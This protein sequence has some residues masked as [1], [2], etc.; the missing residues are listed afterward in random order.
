MTWRQWRRSA[1]SSTVFPW[2]SS[3]QRHV[4][5]VC[6]YRIWP[7]TSTSASR[8]SPPGREPTDAI[9][10]SPPSSIGPMRNWVPSS[11]ESFNG[12]ALFAGPFGLDAACAVVAGDAVTS[13]AVIAAVLRLVDCALLAEL[14]GSWRAPL[15]APRGGARYALDRLS[16]DDG[17][18]AARDRQVQWVIVFAQHA[19]IGLSS[20]G[21][22]DWENRLPRLHRRASG[23]AHLA[24]S[25]RRGR[26]SPLASA[27]RPVCAFWRGQSEVFR[28]ADVA[29]ASAAATDSPLLPHALFAAKVVRGSAA[30]SKGGYRGR[31]CH[32]P[33]PRCGESPGRPAVHS[34]DALMWRCS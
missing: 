31:H 34:S 25:S 15:R 12:S 27:L 17:V 14:P 33:Q 28:W 10:R 23:R 29:V 2:R 3:W 24:P 7:S 6:R 18:V 8:S 19:A 26:Q 30:T 9:D 22:S 32:L 4:C 16:A 20:S 21:E 1:A 5:V 11:S 13:D